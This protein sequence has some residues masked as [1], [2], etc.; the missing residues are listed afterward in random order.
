MKFDIPQSVSALQRRL[1]QTPQIPSS[2]TQHHYTIKFS[3]SFLVT[4]LHSEMLG[5]SPDELEEN[6]LTLSWLFRPHMSSRV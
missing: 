6:S 2:L 4:I 1:P 3:D 5:D